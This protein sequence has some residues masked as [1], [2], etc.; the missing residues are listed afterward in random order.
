MGRR[1]QAQARPDERRRAEINAANNESMPK[2]TSRNYDPKQREFK[3]REARRATRRD[4]RACRTPCMRRARL[5]VLCGE[6]IPRRRHRHGRQAA[7]L[8]R[9]PRRKPTAP[10]EEPQSRSERPAGQDQAFVA[11]G[12]RLRHGDNKA[13]EH[14]EG[15]RD[16]LPPFSAGGQHTAVLEDAT[17]TGRAA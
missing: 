7:P 9:G 14:A 10:E 2:N 1:A 12:S 6:A 13:V 8:H 11:L 17:A 16:E 4:G 3:V 15:A 5:G